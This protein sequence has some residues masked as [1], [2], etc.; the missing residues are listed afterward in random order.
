MRLHYGTGARRGDGWVRSME[1]RYSEADN[2]ESCVG[3]EIAA[4]D[5]GSEAQHLSPQ[6]HGSEWEIEEQLCA[7]NL[8]QMKGIT[9]LS[10]DILKLTHVAVMSGLLPPGARRRK[11]GSRMAYSDPDVAVVVHT[12]FHQAIATIL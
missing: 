4:V 5:Y 10:T 7:P 1:L 8:V 11:C 12:E 2:R 3:D 9:V 6:P